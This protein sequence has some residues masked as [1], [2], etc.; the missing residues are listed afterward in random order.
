MNTG[1]MPTKRPFNWKVFTF[2]A[3]LL[4]PASFAILPFSLTI[5]STTVDPSDYPLLVGLT[6]VNVLIYAALAAVGLFLAGKIG[7]GLPFVEGWLEKEPI[8]GKFRKVLLFSAV[9]GIILGVAIIVL[10]QVVFGPPLQAQFDSLGVSIPE[11]IIP[12]AWEGL[13]ASFSAGFTE[14]VIFRLCGLTVL[15]WL[16]SL[17][18]HDSE[19][20]PRLAIL[21]I[22]NILVATG[23]GLAHLPQALMIG[24]PLTALFVTRT[25][26][27][28]GMGGIFLGWL[29]WKYGLESAMIAHFFADIVLHVILVLIIQ[30]L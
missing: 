20:R 3:V 30:L 16:G 2:L 15:A 4:I 29:Y 8:K 12:P 11:S 25:V 1:K 27:L 5:S 26:I 17:L 19:G 13:L 9:I 22:A 24:I 7:L 14:E 28:N 18:F 23:F 6:F 10:D 21:W